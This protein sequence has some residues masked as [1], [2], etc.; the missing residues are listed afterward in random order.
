MSSDRLPTAPPLKSIRKRRPGEDKRL[1]KIE[2]VAR[3]LQ[4]FQDQPS[5]FDGDLLRLMLSS[6]P[7]RCWRYESVYRE[8]EWCK[9]DRVA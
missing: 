2:L 3:K 1:R 7:G 4:S 6:G 8:S 9:T 5:I